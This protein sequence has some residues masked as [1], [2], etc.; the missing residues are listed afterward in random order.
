M[1]TTVLAWLVAIPLLGMMTGVRTMTPMA[2][3]FWFAY[4]G[5][6]GGADQGNLPLDGTWAF[7]AGRLPSGIIFT[8]L[9][10]GEYIGDKL[11]MTP[12]RTAPGPLLARIV[13]GGL[14]GAIA[15]TG[16]TGSVVEGILLGAFGA[17][18]GTF[19]SFH[20]RRYIVQQSG[21]PDWNVALLEDASA[22]V[23]T[24]VAMRIITA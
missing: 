9:A 11:P 15:A 13:F 4:L 18:A 23:L 1:T 2:V 16:L 17:L 6:H 8:A 12:N 7:W 22:V 20:I 5:H 14:V 10:I 3:G 19:L 24:I 21:R